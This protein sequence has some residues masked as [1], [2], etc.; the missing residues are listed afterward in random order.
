MRDIRYHA[1]PTPGGGSPW[2]R[3]NPI[4]L[5]TPSDLVNPTERVGDVMTATPRTCYPA[6]T[7]IEAVMIFRDADCGIIPITDAGKVLGVLTDRDVAL[8]LAGRE[9]T[10]S[11][12]PV[13]EIM[14][15]DLVT[16]GF[17]DTLD[18]AVERLGNEGVRRL[19]VVDNEGLL[20]GILSWVDLIPHLSER[21]L[22]RVVSLIAEHQR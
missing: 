1:Q 8:A 22:G 13:Q 4:P 19:M 9:T 16:I 2:T 7:V 14:S 15:T 18:V 3:P 5:V 12:T 11:E 21:G 6:S 17:D 20:V 10:L